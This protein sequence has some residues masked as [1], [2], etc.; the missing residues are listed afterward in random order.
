M[1]RT[2]VDRR[3]DNDFLKKKI[4]LFNLWQHVY[5]EREGKN[6]PSKLGMLCC[7]SGW[8]SLGHTS[9]SSSSRS[10]GL[11]VTD[12]FFFLKT[13][14][15]LPGWLQRV[16][17]Q[18]GVINLPLCFYLLEWQTFMSLTI[19]VRLKRSYSQFQWAQM[20]SECWFLQFSLSVIVLSSRSPHFDL[21][22]P[23]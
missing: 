8:C 6:A 22:S 7:G 4:F 12:S 15:G 20:L 9:N 21:F 1:S 10:G 14:H 5:V 17:H 11:R 18:W 13:P 3:E 16:S 23:L 19:R 2:E